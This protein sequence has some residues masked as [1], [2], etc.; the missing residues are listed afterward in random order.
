[1]SIMNGSCLCREVQFRITGDPLI[2]SACYCR[3]CH[4]VGSGVTNSVV[5][6]DETFEL[7]TGNLSIWERQTDKGAVKKM[8]SCSRCN[9]RVYNISSENPNIYRVVAGSLDC[10]SEIVP[11]I[12]LWTSRKLPWLTI[13]EN[14]AQFEKEPDD[15]ADMFTA[16]QAAGGA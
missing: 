1:M 14:A 11:Q 12:H 16:I 8:H 13:P 5:V 10:V 9:S 7:L 4:K 6:F 3:D 2:I 15:P